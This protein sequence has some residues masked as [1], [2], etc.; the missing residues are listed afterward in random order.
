MK[1]FQGFRVLRS[2]RGLTDL[3]FWAFWSRVSAFSWPV[4]VLGMR[5]LG[6]P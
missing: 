2:V 4:L 6:L 3:G 1:V 5:G